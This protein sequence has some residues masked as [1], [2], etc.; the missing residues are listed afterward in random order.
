MMV[1]PLRDG[2]NLVAQEF[3]LCQIAS[4]GFRA[5][6]AARCSS[7]SS[8][9]RRRCSRARCSSTPGTSTASS[10]NSVD[11][12]RAPA[13]ER[14]R[15]L[16]TMA[17]PRRGARQ[18]ALGR[19]LP[20]AARALL[21]ARSADSAAARDRRGTRGADPAR[22]ARARART[23]AARLRR[24]TA[25][26]RAAPD[27][28]AADARDP[29][30]AQRSGGDSR[31]RKSTS[32][33]DAGGETSSSGS[34]GFPI[35]LCA[36]HGYLARA[37][38]EEWRTLV[39]LD[40][41]LAAPH[42]ASA[43]ARRGRRP[44]SARRAQVLQRRLALPPGGA[45]VRLVAGARAPRTTSTSISRVRP[46][47]SF[48]APAWSRCA[49]A[50]STRALYVRSL[51][52]DGKEP[53]HF[54]LGDR[55]RPDRPRPPRCVASGIG[56]RARGRPAPEHACRRPAGGHPHRRPGRG[57]GVPAR[58]RRGGRGPSEPR[59]VGHVTTCYVRLT[60]SQQ[61]DSAPCDEL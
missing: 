49:R 2:M 39:D 50:A 4:P 24:D 25:R 26:V 28:A 21:A 43:T 16:E 35:Y 57:A 12:A 15:R 10:T 44:G 61:A 13:R 5:A 46:R 37:P 51:F 3:V 47:R 58:P 20:D 34:D 14:Q 23:I 32:S 30:A 18:P 56:R 29:I 1:T 54:V 53:T 52:P 41:E 7:P 6:G 17:E 19:G 9:A 40:L 33:A 60:P 27:L 8:P 55:R 45:R 36:E 42:R 31:R 38:G 22:F 59:C 48:R 11:G